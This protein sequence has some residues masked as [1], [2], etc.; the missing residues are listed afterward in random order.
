MS[1]ICA[2]NERFSDALVALAEG[3]YDALVAA[4]PPGASRTK[5]RGRSQAGVSRAG[6]N[7]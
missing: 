1:F 5:L 3:N 7:S 2:D 4:M 6:S